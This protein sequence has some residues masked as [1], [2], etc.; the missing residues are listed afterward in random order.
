[1]KRQILIGLAGLA[2]VS[3]AL[4]ATSSSYVNNSVLIS[5]PATLPV[6]DATNFINNS[7][8][9][10]NGLS[11][12]FINTSFQQVEPYATANTVN[13]TNYGVL[14]SLAGFQFDYFNTRTAQHTMAANLDNEVGA[15]INCGGTNDGPYFT[16]NGT[17]FFGALSGGGA[18][19]VVS[20]TNIINRGTIE[21]GPDSLLSLHGQNVS[22]SGGL[23]NMEGFESGGLFGGL[24]AGLSGGVFGGLFGPAGM[25]DGYWGWGQTP[26]NY[27]PI[28]NFNSFSPSAPEHWVTNRYYSA[29]DQFLSL[30]QATAYLNPGFT[31]GP[32]NFL[33]QIVFL[34]NADQSLSNNVYFPGIPVVEWVWPSTN[35]I[36]GLVQT[37]HL[38]FEDAMITF[39]NLALTT[40]GIAPPNTGYGVTFIP[41]NY[42]FFQS[43]SFFFGTPATPGLP[44]GV[45]GPNTNWTTEYTAYE[46]IFQ[47]TTVILGEVA[48][49]TFTN[50]PGRI[51]VTADKQLDLRSS[52]IAGLNYLRLTAT[53]NFT[54]D[55]N[56]RI[57]TAY[58]DYNLGVTNATM[59]V[60]NLLAPTCPRLNGYVD[61]F[62]TRWTNIDSAFITNTYYVTM[63]DSHLA[64]SSPSFLQNLTLHA[65]NVVISDV[66][67][68]LSN[69]TIDAFNLT[70]ATNGPGSQ[71]PAG[72]LNIPSGLA[73]DASALPRLRT[74]T[75]YGVISVQNSA[76]FGSSTQPYWD[77]V[78]RGSVLV[79][80][81]SIWATNFDNTGLIDSGPGP[82]RIAATSAMLS[83][84]VFK[85]PVSD[86]ILSAGSLFITNQFLNAGHSL[87]IWATN[88]LSDGGPASGNVWLAGVLGFNLPILPPV[89][90]LLGTTITDTAPAWATVS[91]QWAG[92]DRGPVA[93]GYSDNAALGRLILDGGTPGSSFV[94]NAPGG[95]NALY[96]DY[97]EFRNYL[98]NFD[99]S[100]NL[101]N[102]HFAQEF[103]SGVSMKIY[104]AQLIINGVSWAEKLNHKNGGGLN[105]VA[106]YAGAFSS[107][108]M[109]YPTEGTTN[110]LNLALVLSCD[111]DSN[112]NGIANCQD[113]EPVFVPSQLGLAA[114]LTNAPQPAVVLSWN[115]IPYST[116]S[117]FF[118]PSL[119]AT[120]WQ[121]LTN[122]VLG[123]AGG[124]QRI[125]DPL[126]AGDRFYRVRVDGVSP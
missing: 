121:L 15:I 98:T 111:L 69:I 56:T 79:Q 46:A 73:L 75:N 118:K 55:R 7:A 8:F 104:Y 60:S 19:C 6:V 30:P 84:G 57:L 23:L 120:N 63:V 58:A 14:G 27:N 122:F 106:A 94:F 25:F 108:N 81:C 4:G 71:T 116:N 123:P 31:V 89:G 78:N 11:L 24:F 115:S 85:A 64:S 77:F 109:Y 80:G 21:M 42:S 3:V 47:P 100:G 67:N 48:G 105:W 33:W 35:I 26:K 37:N 91:S 49:Q 119:T 96:V 93:A 112:G 28:A 110:R 41:T 95:N 117:V 29:M 74:L 53:N 113:L 125:V 62:S 2:M 124:R 59:T 61:V 102:L 22:L 45:I 83:N 9:I 40:N 38:Y 34:Q 12:I 82:I 18:V 16:T 65:T 86:I 36:T 88:S 99:G 20:A 10:D 52:R 50:M 17:F 72:Q 101:A 5:P 68:V 97:L 90:S 87:T 44:P 1:M 70:I 126:T 54:Q 114:A 43:S 66:L 92:Q 76:T 13:Y 107:T 51:E 32:S 103:D 39:T